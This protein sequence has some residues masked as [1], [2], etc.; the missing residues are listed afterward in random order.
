MKLFLFLFLAA[1]PAFAA[2]VSHEAVYDIGLSSSAGGASGVVSARG[3]MRYT[4]R[5]NCSV[6]N[7]ETV[8][9]TDVAYE[10]AGVRTTH[11]KQTTKETPDGCLFDFEVFSREKGRDKKEL[12]G[13]A[14]CEN[15]KKKLKI[16][17]PTVMFFDFPSSV[18]FPVEQ[19]FSLVR[20]MKNNEKE[21]KTRFYDGTLPVASAVVAARLSPSSEKAALPALNGVKKSKVDLAFY[22]R[23][24]ED[25]TPAYEV[26]LRLYE[27]GVVDESV[28][29]F[30]S[31]VLKSTLRSLTFLPDI[32]CAP[33]R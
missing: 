19:T 16:I 7:T 5:K 9:S 18:R 13:S 21:V 12:A 25:G 17:H 2:P 6:W 24:R 23:D 3:V 31:H 32:P 28:Q 27:N 33:A 11:W 29:D 10:S 30:G 20:A 14:R 22:P 8:F 1:A 4:L 26:S 15:G